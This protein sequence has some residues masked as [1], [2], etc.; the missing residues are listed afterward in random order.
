LSRL[1]RLAYA[2]HPT[3]VGGH[4][5]CPGTVTCNMCGVCVCQLYVSRDLS[6][7]STLR[8]C[9]ELCWGWWAD[10]SSGFATSPDERPRYGLRSIND[11]AVAVLQFSNEVGR[12]SRPQSRQDKTG[13]GPDHDLRD[14]S[15]YGGSKRER[16]SVGNHV[17]N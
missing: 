14:R 16:E 8:I 1:R 12:G 3:D 13:N 5:E 2:V 6:M 4:T 11:S 15:W 10:H 9:F 17:L 7:T